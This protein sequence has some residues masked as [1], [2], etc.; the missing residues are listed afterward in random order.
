V[1]AFATTKIKASEDRVAEALRS[2]MGKLGQVRG[3]AKF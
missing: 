3:D 1:E 2:R